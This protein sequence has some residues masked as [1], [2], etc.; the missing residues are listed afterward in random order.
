MAHVEPAHL[1][2]L[3]LGN[4]VSRNDLSAFRHIAVCPRCQDE[5]ARLT[6]VVTAARSIDTSDLLTAP[7]EQVWERITLEL[8]GQ[9][10]A[11]SPPAAEAVRQHPHGVRGERRPGRCDDGTR[12]RPVLLGL[13]IGLVVGRWFARRRFPCHLPRY[14]WG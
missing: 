14:W 6:R 3:A 10:E 4:A 11:T 8:S 5:L 12:A 2:E 13:L 1:V 9:A 7:P